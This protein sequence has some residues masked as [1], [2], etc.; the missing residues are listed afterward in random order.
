MNTTTKD[1]SAAVI[2]TVEPDVYTGL[3]ER[4]ILNR[5]KKIAEAERRKKE[6]EKEIETLRAEIIGDAEML[7]RETAD[8]IVRYTPVTTERIDTK[9]FKEDHPALAA[10]YTKGTTSMRFSYKLK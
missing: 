3:T 1:S 6:L 2:W 5:L 4:Q 9:R 8:F 7:A 10:A